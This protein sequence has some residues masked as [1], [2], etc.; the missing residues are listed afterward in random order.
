MT[1]VTTKKSVTGEKNGENNMNKIPLL[2]NG[3]WKMI[4]DPLDYDAFKGDLMKAMTAAGYNHKRM[5]IG[6]YDYASLIVYIHARGAEPTPEHPYYAELCVS[7]SIESYL[8]ATD[9]DLFEWLAKASPI[10]HASNASEEFKLKEE[11]L[12]RQFTE[13]KERQKR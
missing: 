1:T 5:M 3:T 13:E 4:D 9:I 10:V 2:E 6:S 8:L 12:S 7:D 11:R